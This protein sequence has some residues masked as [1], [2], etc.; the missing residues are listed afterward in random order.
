MVQATCHCAKAGFFIT[1]SGI[2]F[3]FSLRE[4]Y[5]WEGRNSI[6]E[7]ALF[8]ASSGSAFE[9][10]K[11][12]AI[13]ASFTGISWCQCTFS[14]HTP[15]KHLCLCCGT[16]MSHHIPQKWSPTFLRVLQSFPWLC[17]EFPSE[18]KRGEQHSAREHPCKHCRQSTCTWRR[19]VVP[20]YRG[21]YLLLATIRSWLKPNNTIH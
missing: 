7:N 15:L 9:Q 10:Q 20:F 1:F 3:T 8:L 14:E 19:D 18:G 2:F 4:N 5:G 21:C 12:I 17:P 16:G 11:A 6:E 13:S